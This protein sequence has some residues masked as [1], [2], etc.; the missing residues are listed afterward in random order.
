[1]NTPERSTFYADNLNIS[2][3]PHPPIERGNAPRLNAWAD[4]RLAIYA[5]LDA[6]LTH[7][8]VEAI[9]SLHELK[10]AVEEDAHQTILN[11]TSERETLLREVR[12]L[13]LEQVQLLDELKQ[14][15]RELEEAR[16]TKLAVEHETHYLLRESE[17]ERERIQHE[18]THLT[19]QMDVMGQQMQT[20]LQQ[21]FT[22]IW[23]SFVESVVTQNPSNPRLS[24]A[25]WGPAMKQI[26]DN[27]AIVASIFKSDPTRIEPTPLS[28]STLELEGLEPALFEP[29]PTSALGLPAKEAK[30]SDRAENK[31]LDEELRPA[32]SGTSPTPWVTAVEPVDPSSN[33]AESRPREWHNNKM[34]PHILDNLLDVMPPNFISP[35]STNATPPVTYNRR[36][37]DRSQEVEQRIQRLRSLRGISSA[38]ASEVQ[39]KEE[40][41]LVES[42]SEVISEELDLP[43]EDRPTVIPERLQPNTRYYDKARDKAELEEIG[44]KL[45]FEV[46]TPP[47]LSAVRFAPGFKPRGPRLPTRS[48]ADLSK[49]HS[50]DISPTVDYVPGFLAEPTVE[51]AVDLASSSNLSYTE[52]SKSR[53]N[54]NTEETE[55]T[56]PAPR[57]GDLGDDMAHQFSMANLPP[58][59][60]MPLP[61]I[62]PGTMGQFAR[63]PLPLPQGG[64]SND[65]NSD[66][67]IETKLTISNLQGLSLL[68]MEKVVR[69]LDGIHHVTVTDF[70][71]GVLEMDVR[72]S[73]DVKLEEVLPAMTDLKLM[74]V[75]RGPNSLEFLQEK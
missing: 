45:G 21:R 31:L 26:L 16:A 9:R 42:K 37:S 74:L 8:M 36:R 24:E 60:L 58:M 7:H 41:S 72:H 29:D 51:Q 63:V 69:G 70:R 11:L 4:E 5:S 57:I 75:E 59:P 73:S 20:F 54:L 27:P 52:A 3:P 64:S 1:M 67:D 12:E 62:Q 43:F 22:Q 6:S 40:G 48:S 68:M 55:L 32:E 49:S 71:K 18:I 10:H 66:D 56:T 13:R 65:H 50:G 46:A 44:A 35:R 53:P 25:V 33:L 17:V 23:E 28:T 61:D 38:Q 19:S 15:Q 34:T 30:S 14:A 2:L 39:P 47:S